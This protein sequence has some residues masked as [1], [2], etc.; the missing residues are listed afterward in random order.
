MDP[1]IP[2]K[3]IN[4]IHMKD[5][6]IDIQVIVLEKTGEFTIKGGSKIFQFLVADETGC[7]WC[8]F[9]D[10]I[11][12]LIQPSDILQIK[13]AYAT[14]YKR[15]LLLYT[16]KVGFGYINKKGQFFMASVETPNLSAKEYTDEELKS[17]II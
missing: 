3:K 10:D 6:S 12:D 5:K 8:N 11:G 7:I 14:I 16:P 17:D 1:F 9:Y 13:G 2:N 4:D 15:H